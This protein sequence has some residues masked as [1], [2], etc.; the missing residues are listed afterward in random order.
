MSFSGSYN[1]ASNECSLQVAEKCRRSAAD[2]GG[3]NGLRKYFSRCPGKQIKV[4]KGIYW[5]MLSALKTDT[6]YD[7]RVNLR[8]NRK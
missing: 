8:N 4:F 1:L 5:E 7:S 3:T 2:V 6:C